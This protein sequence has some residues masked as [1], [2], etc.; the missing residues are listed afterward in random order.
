M[1]RQD[2]EAAGMVIGAVVELETEA[3]FANRGGAKAEQRCPGEDLPVD[4]DPAVEAAKD[5]LGVAPGGGFRK[6]GT[7]QDPDRPA[8]PIVARGVVLL[9][10]V[11]DEPGPEN[12][13][14]FILNLKT[15]AHHYRGRICGFFSGYQL[16]QQVLGFRLDTE[17]RGHH[18]HG[19]AGQQ[20]Q[21]RQGTLAK[22]AQEGRDRPV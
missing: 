6:D 16:R 8:R 14:V 13:A 21:R 22:G 3:H 12:E 2:A 10:E 19:S 4:E 17:R 1:N 9:Q 11:G 5:A 15:P 18:V 20:G 7:Q